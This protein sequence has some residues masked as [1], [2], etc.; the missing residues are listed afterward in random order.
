MDPLSGKPNET[1]MPGA[2]LFACSQNAV[3]S[4]MAEAMMKYLFPGR[5]YVQSAGVHEGEADGFAVAVMDEIGLDIQSHHP[6]TFEAI[7]DSTFDV[8]VTLSPEAHHQ[9]LEFTRTMAVDVEY[10]PTLDP[11]ASE[12]S[13]ESRLAV[14]RSIR[15]QLMQ[16]IKARFA[17]RGGPSV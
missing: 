11:A 13:R 9:A 10:W 14:Y 4:P 2:I 17:W 8:I 15:D 3:R 16:K 12:G 5:V 7:E 1:E 6:R